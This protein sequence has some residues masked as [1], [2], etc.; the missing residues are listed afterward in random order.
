MSAKAALSSEFSCSQLVIARIQLL[1]HGEM[2]LLLFCTQ[3]TWDY[4]QHLGTALRSWP[5]DALHGQ[6]TIQ[7]SV[8]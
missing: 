1:A 8:R 5:L 2:E 6:F 3:L 7:A 4:S